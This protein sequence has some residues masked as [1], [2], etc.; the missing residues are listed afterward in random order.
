[1][2]SKLETKKQEI[3]EAE[4]LQL[5]TELSGKSEIMEKAYGGQPRW[6]VDH[7]QLYR[8]FIAMLLTRQSDF[9]HI[10]I[11]ENGSYYF[12]LNN[13]KTLRIKSLKYDFEPQELTDEI[14]F[15]DEQGLPCELRVGAKP[16]E[17]IYQKS[18]DPHPEEKW[19]RGHKVIELI[20]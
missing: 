5:L 6:F 10:F 8:D 7:P 9:K 4:L 15:S 14:T 18:A 11:T 19:H 20:K 13:G 12:V 1:M 17:T 2:E 16:F 3:T